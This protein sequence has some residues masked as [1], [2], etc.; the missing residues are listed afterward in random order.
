MNIRMTP[1]YVALALVVWTLGASA[2]GNQPKDPGWPRVFKKDGKELTV[3]QPQVDYWNGYTNL[4]FRCAIG[5]KGVAK[6]ERFGVVEADALTVVDQGARLVA[7]IPSKRE[8]RFANVKEG[9]LAK[10]R[11]AVDQ[12]HPPGQA[13]TLSL[14]RVIACLDPASQPTQKPVEVC[15]DPPRVFSSSTPAILVIFMGEP[16]LKP[17]ETNRTDLLFALNTNWDV[18]YDVASQRYFLLL[19][20]GWLT[21]PDLFK[22]PWSPAQTLPPSI[23]ALPNTE[24][25]AEARKRLPGTPAKSSPTVFASTEP[26]ELI[27]TDGP[28]T[29]TPVKSTKLLRVSNTA[30]VVFLNSGDG[31]MYF[32]VAGRWFRAGSLNG[33]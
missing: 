28:P 5:V 13:I 21:T 12:L 6:Q 14:D 8:L 31:K 30:S 19:G 33:P 10:L 4:H 26:A 22:G 3:Y 32:L 2:A 20:D 15:I 24:N 18:L 27:L 17:V 11:Q 23:H 1:H 25:W 16:Q 9:E 29:F 7:I